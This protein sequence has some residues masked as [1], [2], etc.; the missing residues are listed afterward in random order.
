MAEQAIINTSTLTS[1]GDA[2][3]TKTGK[4]DTFL[5]S[6]M[7]TE[8]LAIETGSD[9][10]GVTATASDVRSGKKFV[11]SSGTVVTGSLTTRTSSSL[12]AS[13]ATVSV[14]AGIYDSTVSKSI[15]TATQAT[16]SISVSSSG[17]ITAQTTQSAGYVSSGTKSATLQLSSSQDSDF[18]ASNIKNGVTIFGITGTMET[19]Y[20]A[21]ASPSYLSGSIRI[22][23]SG[24]S[25]VLGISMAWQSSDGTIFQ[26]ISGTNTGGFMSLTANTNRSVAS[27]DTVNV[28]VASNTITL[29]GTEIGSLSIGEWELQSCYITY[30]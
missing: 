24:V 16:P 14:P 25:T 19:A 17:L 4:T 11:N 29:S 21:S 26:M 12:S 7:P 3:R 15:S 9:V 22:Y 8:I 27:F 1:I 28:E 20:I 2:I 5:P 18:I 6:D 23:F 13:G 30:R 10:S